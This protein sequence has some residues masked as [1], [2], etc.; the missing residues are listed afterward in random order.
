MLYS[1]TF[2]DEFT[3]TGRWHQGEEVKIREVLKK[4]LALNICTAVTLMFVWHYLTSQAY[5][6]QASYQSW[7]KSYFM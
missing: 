5:V 2:M 4:Q 1:T 7:T 6:L 3:D